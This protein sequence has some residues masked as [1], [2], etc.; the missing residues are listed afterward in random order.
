[1]RRG[2]FFEADPDPP[3]S[4]RGNWVIRDHATAPRPGRELIA[5]GG[6][7]EHRSLARPFLTILR[8]NL[9]EPSG[10]LRQQRP[11][12]LPAIVRIIIGMLAV[13]WF[14]LCF[15]VAWLIVGALAMRG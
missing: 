3:G 2:D 13:T 5:V 10:A 4:G 12:R 7:A 8:W 15:L 14:V 11:R 6:C 1:M 9:R